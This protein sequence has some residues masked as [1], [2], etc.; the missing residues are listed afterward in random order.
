MIRPA[1][2]PPRCGPPIS[3]NATPNPA[4]NVF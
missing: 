2:Q 4:K 3:F 1:H